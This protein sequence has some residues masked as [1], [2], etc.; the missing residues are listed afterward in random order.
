MQSPDH[1]RGPAEINAVSGPVSALVAQMQVEL[2]SLVTRNDELRRR[3]HSIRRVV[4]GLEGMVSGSVFDYRCTTSQASLADH[5]IAGRSRLHRA[6]GSGR[7]SN[8]A[9]VSLLRACRI[10]LMETETATSLEEIYARIVR[11]GSFSFVSLRRA[12]PA[13]VRVLSAMAEEGEV[14]LLKNGPRWRWE[15]IALVDEIQVHSVGPSD[16]YHEAVRQSA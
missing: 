16:D 15:R 4:R 6:S 8:Q 5:L 3:I 11:R 14:R 2:R 10:A 13:L 9:D 7:R 1:H 12:S